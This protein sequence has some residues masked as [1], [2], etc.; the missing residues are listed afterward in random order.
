MLRN[1]S[2]QSGFTKVYYWVSSIWI[3]K[4]NFRNLTTFSPDDF[5][6][7]RAPPLTQSTVVV[8]ISELAGGPHGWYYD[9]PKLVE[10][11]KQF[12][13][14]FFFCNNGCVFPPGI[15]R[16]RTDRPPNLAQHAFTVCYLAALFQKIC[17]NSNNAFIRIVQ[18]VGIKIHGLTLYTIPI[19]SPLPL[20]LLPFLH[21]SFFPFHGRRCRSPPGSHRLACSTPVQCSSSSSLSTRPTSL[22]TRIY[23][24]PRLSYST[25]QWA[26]AQSRYAH[27]HPRILLS[28]R[29]TTIY[30]SQYQDGRSWRGLH[31]TPPRIVQPFPTT[32]LHVL[33]TK[34]HDHSRCGLHPSLIRYR[35][36]L[37]WYAR[38]SCKN[39]RMHKDNSSPLW[40]WRRLDEPWCRYRSSY[41]PWVSQQLTFHQL[42]D[43]RPPFK[44]L[45]E[46]LRSDLYSLHQAEQHWLAYHL[47]FHQWR[48]HSYQ[49]HPLLGG[50]TQVGSLYQMGSRRYLFTTQVSILSIS[51]KKKISFGWPSC[52]SFDPRCI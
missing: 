24:A 9:S 19:T 1:M 39:S 22:H 50:I 52:D 7:F 46:S 18:S 37:V 35:T 30:Q 12:S 5:Q 49:R 26:W 14:Y 15:W 3:P 29:R 17:L 20:P 23:R 11:M 44:S 42:I 13:T 4:L 32:I 43:S 28:A 51:P 10:T 40:S 25:P 36:R 38:C 16:T 21:L 27:N 41:G 2:V 48:S 8:G 31:A 34:T 47:P 6:S 33:F 45:R